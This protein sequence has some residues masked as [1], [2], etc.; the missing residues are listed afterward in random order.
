MGRLMQYFFLRQEDTPSVILTATSGDTAARLPRV[1]WPRQ[2][3]GRRVYPEREVTER[4]RKQM[5]TLAKNIQ[6]I[7]IN[8]KFDDCQA[9]VNAHLQILS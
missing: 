1:L 4:Q 2:H 3:P 6:I 8:G 5:T 9:L 7:A